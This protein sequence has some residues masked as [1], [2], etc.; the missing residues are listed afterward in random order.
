M[1]ELRPNSFW[2]KNLGTAGGA[3]CPNQNQS[4]TTLRYANT[5]FWTFTECKICLLS[6]SG[7]KL[8]HSYF[9]GDQRH[10]QRRKK[11]RYIHV[12]YAPIP[13]IHGVNF[14]CKSGFLTSKP[15]LGTTHSL[16]CSKDAKNRF[17]GKFY[18][19]IHVVIRKVSQLFF[20]SKKMIFEK[21]KI[22]FW[23]CVIW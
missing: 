1:F 7:P 6:G 12:K 23:K 18:I 17:F 14:S 15:N 3:D 8:E 20:R 13:S 11:I 22:F 9:K 4:A 10:W 21:W 2:K 16:K 19:D 5:G